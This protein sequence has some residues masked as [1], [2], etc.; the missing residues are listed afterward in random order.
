M[1]VWFGGRSDG[2]GEQRARALFYGGVESW[3][4]CWGRGDGIGFW[5]E[6]TGLLLGW[7]GEWCVRGWEDGGN[8]SG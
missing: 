3:E 7:G 2:D 4:G 8:A 6:E 1:R 5:G